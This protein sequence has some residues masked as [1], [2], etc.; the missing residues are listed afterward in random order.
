[1]C[2]CG[3]FAQP[4]AGASVQTKLALWHRGSRW[5]LAGSGSTKMWDA[6]RRVVRRRSSWEGVL[7]E[8]TPAGAPTTSRFGN[9]H[10]GLWLSLQKLSLAPL[11]TPVAPRRRLPWKWCGISLMPGGWRWVTCGPAVMRNGLQS[12]TLVNGGD[13]RCFVGGILQNLSLILDFRGNFFF[14]WPS[15]TSFFLP[16]LSDTMCSHYM[17]IYQF[18]SISIYLYI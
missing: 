9:Q 4:G 13:C 7:G 15:F 3:A 11:E 17:Y 10:R 6:V 12:A 5:L 18:I 1:M 8:A 14:M 16:F 2:T